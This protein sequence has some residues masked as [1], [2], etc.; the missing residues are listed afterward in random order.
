M[1]YDRCLIN[2]K[3]VAN[4]YQSTSIVVV[5]LRRNIEKQK[6]VK[7]MRECR[8]SW[9]NRRF[10]WNRSEEFEIE[11]TTSGQVNVFPIHRWSSVVINCSMLLLEH[12]CRKLENII[13]RNKSMFDVVRIHNSLI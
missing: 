10:R 2:K 7:T 8:F 6:F 5:V 1:N 12:F 9:N 4:I 3:L 13:I 11:I